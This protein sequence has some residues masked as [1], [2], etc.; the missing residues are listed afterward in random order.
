MEVVA[1]LVPA[2]L[3]L[4]AAIAMR[5]A[6]TENFQ[7][8]LA[9]WARVLPTPALDAQGPPVSQDVGS[10]PASRLGQKP[11]HES[12]RMAEADPHV[13]SLRSAY[14]VSGSSGVLMSDGPRLLDANVFGERGPAL[15]ADI[16]SDQPYIEFTAPSSTV[17]LLPSEFVTGTRSGNE[18]QGRIFVGQYVEHAQQEQWEALREETYAIVARGRPRVPSAIMEAL[19][20]IL[21]LDVRFE[22]AGDDLWHAFARLRIVLFGREA[23][24]DAIGFS[25]A[26]LDEDTLAALVELV[27]AFDLLKQTAGSLPSAVGHE[28]AGAREAGQASGKPLSPGSGARRS[29]ADPGGRK[30][31]HPTGRSNADEAS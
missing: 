21:A 2:S 20:A 11:A 8:I 1:F 5:R 14:I 26:A 3:A 27:C 13:A 16:D 12:A 24:L 28:P 15:S 25:H 18:G 10:G 6:L 7:E 9:A 29:S 17:D 31:R 4:V 30:A 19:E 22:Q 23:G